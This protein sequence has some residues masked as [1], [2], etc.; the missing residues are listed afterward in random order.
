VNE[1]E[2]RRM[3]AERRQQLSKKNQPLKKRLQEIEKKIGNLE[4]RKKEIEIR[5]ADPDFYKNGR[6]VKQISAEYR[7]VQAR[8]DTFLLEWAEVSDR[9]KAELRS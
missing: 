1:K 2:R 6:E 5:M 7:D 8:L 3:E 9:L 4:Q